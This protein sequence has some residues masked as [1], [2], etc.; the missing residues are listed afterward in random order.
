MVS[1]KFFNNMVPV[2]I[3]NTIFSYLEDTTQIP[4]LALLPMKNTTNTLMLECSH[5]LFNE[6]SLHEAFFIQAIQRLL[7]KGRVPKQ[8]I[9]IKSKKFNISI[10]LDRIPVMQY[11]F[12]K[13]ST[14]NEM[15]SSIYFEMR[16]IRNKDKTYK[17]LMF[18]KGKIN[19]PGI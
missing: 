2:D 4:Y 14:K 5:I 3:C 6:F 15:N 7:D 8:L 18:R 9:C 19:I 11:V 17:I 16:S 1:Q 10:D 13:Q 12:Q